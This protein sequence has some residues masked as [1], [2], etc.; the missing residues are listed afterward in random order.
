MDMLQERMDFID[1]GSIVETRIGGYPAVVFK[2]VN[3][4][5]PSRQAFVVVNGDAYTILG[6]PWDPERFPDGIPQLDRVWETTV[7]NLRFFDP[8][9]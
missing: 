7:G 9:R 2:D 3:G 6:Q 4:A 5:W 8:W 1:P